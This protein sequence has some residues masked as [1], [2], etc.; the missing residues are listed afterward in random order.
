MK[1]HTRHLA[2]VLA[3]LVPVVAHPGTNG[4]LE[5]V[6]TTEGTGEELPGANVV[7]SGT[8]L[9][10]TTGADGSYR[11]SNI[12]AGYYEIHFT[13]IGYQTL[14]ARCRPLTCAG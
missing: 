1:A 5:G 11:I 4:S 13:L 9:G 14:I 12:P 6:V 10:G 2:L 3:I 7:V 8:Q